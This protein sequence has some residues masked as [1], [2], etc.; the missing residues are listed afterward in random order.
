[1]QARPPRSSDPASRTALFPSALSKT[2]FASPD[3]RVEIGVDP[4]KAAARIVGHED[5]IR[6]CRRI[7][8]LADQFLLL[9]LEGRCDLDRFAEPHENRTRIVRQ[10]LR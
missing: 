7:V 1:M 9:R 4:D 5:R 8:R 2:D 3:A 10:S 6:R